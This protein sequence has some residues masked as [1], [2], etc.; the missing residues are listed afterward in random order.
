MNWAKI[1]EEMAR[2]Y[3]FQ[4]R[5]GS[6]LQTLAELCREADNGGVCRYDDRYG[7]IGLVGSIPDRYEAGSDFAGERMDSRLLCLTAAFGPEICSTHLT[8]DLRSFWIPRLGSLVSEI[9]LL[10]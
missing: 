8:H 5:R 2:E 3:G 7:V 6:M 9:R 1:T 10:A 4:S